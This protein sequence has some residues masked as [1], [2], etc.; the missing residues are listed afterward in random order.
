MKQMTID[1]NEACSKTAYLFSE[2]A[3][4]YPITPS[5][6]MAEHI[7]EWSNQGKL[8]VFNDKV[9]V[10]EMQSEG[11][12]SGFIHGALQAGTL[13]TT[14]TASQGLLLM[15]PNM[16]KMAG[17]MLPCVIHVAARTLSTHALSIFGDH[18]DIYAC[19]QTG[20]CM[21]A[22]SSVQD[23]S[24]LSAI[25]HL[26]AIESS[27]P[28]MHFFDGFRTSHEINKINILE[29]QEYKK[30][31]NK[32]AVKKFRK[33]A[34]N[35][36]NP[37][38]KGTAV[39]GDIYF[40][41]TEA[42]NKS[43]LNVPDIVNEYM[44]KINKLTDSNYK[45][46]N[47]YGSKNAKNIIVAMGSVNETIKE[48]IEYLNKDIG[49]I[50]V[51]LYRP[52]SQ[53]YLLDVLPGTVKNIAVLD[54]T[55][56]AGSIGEPLYLDI[57]SALKDKNINIVGGRYGLASKDVTP[58][59]I[60]AI[61]NMLE[62]K[63]KNNFTIGIEDD[64]TNLSLKSTNL[65][66]KKHNEFLI[67]G[68]GSDGMV[69]ASKSLIKMIGS[70][71]FNVQGYFEYDSKKSGGVTVCHL[72]FGKEKIKSTY[73]V[74][75]P[76]L[77]VL[78]KDSYLEQFN[79]LDNIEENG[80]FIISTSKSLEELNE[81]ISKQMLNII[82][83]RNINVYISRAMELA[84][85]KGLGN[86]ISMIME[87]QILKLSN[88][89][90]YDEAIDKLI[91]DVKSKFR[92]KGD[93]VIDKNI[94]AIKE[95][96]KY[97][98][99]IDSFKENNLTINVENNLYDMINKRHGNE[100]KV[101]D[102]VN[103]MD[104]T[105]LTETSKY[106]K[107]MISE[108][109][110]NWIKENCISCNQCSFVCPHAVIRP[111]LLNQ[112]EY[113][114]S[115]HFI[116]EKCIKP[117]NPK[118]KDYYF[119]IA[120]SVKDCT[121]C[122]LCIKTCPGKKMLKALEY[123]NINEALNLKE[124]ERFDYLNENIMD[125]NIDTNS[126][127]TCQFKKPGFE[128]S[129]ACSGCGETAYL[130]LLTQLFGKELIISNATGC[131]SI[132]GASMPSMPYSVPFASSLFE[133]NAEY[134]YGILLGNK[135][136]KNRVKE[137]MEKDNNPLFKKWLENSDDYNIT[138][139]VY[140]N[141]DYNKYKN[142]K[143]IKDYIVK[144]SVWTIGGDGWA[145]DIG[146]SGIDHILSTNDDV[147]ILVLNTQVYSNTGGQTSKATPEG[148]VASFSSS[149]KKV[150]Q[151]N[152][153]KIALSYPHVYVAQINLGANMLQV[154][155]ALKEAEKYKG[156]SIII[157]YAPC[158]SHGINEGMS[159]SLNVANLATKC[160]FYPIFRYNPET[161]KFI[162]DSKNVNFDLYDEFLN[163]QNR[164][165]ILS[166]VNKEEANILLEKNKKQAIDDFNYYKK[167]EESE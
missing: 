98:Y 17:E 5:S 126:V 145:Y 115:P 91:S 103:N 36:L 114:N 135:V 30:L 93:E 150:A 66:I 118:L 138:K 1:G 100:L 134:G 23:A 21:L 88:L 78:T 97:I 75:N 119:T 62:N 125:K 44:E 165:K 132:Y 72:R 22:S 56:E 146:F 26:S 87:A 102:F 32:E 147:N 130:K 149:G 52:F 61:Y 148:M 3:G 166:K 120:I 25:A 154:I 74:S 162:L 71:D 164:F 33:R 128:F 34:L 10:V 140:D 85:K 4:I 45:P 70:K 8:N 6:T 57:L 167:L 161:K 28:F 94:S 99:K 64:V 113:D 83:E 73:F 110:P 156:P 96:D 2:I 143:E 50:E 37:S 63:P 48:V 27:L 117:L 46:F 14:F 141:I 47:Y 80:T 133:D 155:K 139:E 116:K 67:Y 51:H 95:S 137:E 41:M 111:Y 19:R 55:K 18:Q 109:V 157:A 42:R 49:L 86:K 105:Y 144:R 163:S 38:T 121:G 7:D 108:N 79:L 24:Y 58:G 76:K 54:R 53:K 142:L 68:Y 151:K 31:I 136:M 153:A 159:N 69:S 20:F 92:K 107:R 59:D 77:I 82:K 35:P 29:D 131:S 160:G 127:M 15:I 90:D 16:Y 13:A 12:A 39:N 101:S 60:E 9:K 89:L 129:G 112:I 81:M 158:I 104:G 152:L 11:G 84:L 65:K 43:Y 124:Q 106:D 123:Q 40:Q 122:G